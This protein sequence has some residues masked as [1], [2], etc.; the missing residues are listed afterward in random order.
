MCTKF[1]AWYVSKN[2]HSRKQQIRDAIF[3]NIVNNLLTDMQT[4]NS[5]VQINEIRIVS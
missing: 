3:A 5:H 4:N 1:I 2:S